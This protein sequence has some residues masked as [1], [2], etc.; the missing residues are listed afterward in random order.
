MSLICSPSSQVGVPGLPDPT[1]VPQLVNQSISAMASRRP[2]LSICLLAF[3][4]CFLAP[5]IS[6]DKEYYYGYSVY[7]MNPQTTRQLTAL[8][9]LAS[10]DTVLMKYG[11]DFWSEPSTLNRSVDIL[12]PPAAQNVI[13]SFAR[14]FDIAM[15]LTIPDVQR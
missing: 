1:L 7:R 11:L 6:A 3:L 4:V 5:E 10:D 12:T 2:S 9:K 13:R 14:H 15:D 8:R